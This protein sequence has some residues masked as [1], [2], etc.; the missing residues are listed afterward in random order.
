[1]TG[2][3]ETTVQD[4]VDVS[5]PSFRGFVNDR[6]P[7]RFAN[8]DEVRAANLANVNLIYVTPRLYE[9]D[10]SDTTSADDGSSVIHDTNG[11]AFKYVAVGIAVTSLGGAWSNA[12]SYGV[13]VLVSHGGQLFI[14]RT[15]GNLNN[16]PNSSTPGD[17]TYW[18]LVPTISGATVIGTSTTS[19]TIGTGTRVFTVNAGIAWGSG[20][21]LRAASDANPTTHYMEGVVASYVGGTLTV[22]VDNVEGSGSR[23]DWTISIAGDV[24]SQGPSGNDGTNGIDGTSAFTV[25]RVV[26]TT[27]VDIATALENGDAIDGV[28]IA[29]N[30]QVLLTGQSAPAQNGV[31]VVPASGSASR[32][33][34]FDAYDELPG[35][36]FSVM[37]GSAKADTLWRCTSNRGG[38]IDVTALTFS[39]FTAGGGGGGGDGALARVRAVATGNLA[40]A[41]DLQNGDT[42]DGVTLATGDS[43]LLTGQTVQ[44]ENGVYTVVAA[45]AASR[46]ADFTS[47][48]A[49]AGAF[50][51]VLEGTNNADSL[52]TCT[53]DQG[54]TIGVTAV[55]ISEF[56]PSVDED[57]GL[58]TGSLTSQADYGSIA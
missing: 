39:E 3:I 30:D 48:D 45:G 27:D 7:H 2:P 33:T 50:F 34:S 16:T 58:I 41:T 4:G 21:R 53:S 1:M 46:Q 26:A 57:Y 20:T 47:F 9:K 12:T 10:T 25:V 31:Y 37:E 18:M 23:A 29:T 17:T 14:S 24:G 55:A 22:T 11:T 52:W 40:T 35:I 42:V 5:K 8:A 28:T 19:L 6:M 36:H 13:G 32:S 15:E 49:L 56:T 54:G 44:A 43:V 38:T 51:S